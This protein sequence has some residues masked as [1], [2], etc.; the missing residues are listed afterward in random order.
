MTT[1][2]KTPRA[3]KRSAKHNAPDPITAAAHA[4]ARAA[5]A[6]A[7]ISRLNAD[8][9]L[10]ATSADRDLQSDTRRVRLRARDLQR[11]SPL[12]RRYL[13]LVKQNVVGSA[14]PRLQATNRGRDGKLD[15]ALNRYLEQQFREWAKRV[16]V[17]GRL[18]LL[19]YLWLCVSSLP[20]DGE[21]FT[22]RIV[23]Y[24]HN[25][26]GFALQALEPDLCDEQH[27]MVPVARTGRE[28][29]LGVEVDEWQRPVQYW[30][31]D[32]YPG[33]S[34]RPERIP[35]PASEVYHM[36]EP[37]R[38]VQTRGI[39]WL[40]AVMMNLRHVDGYV[41]AE[42]VATRAGSTKLGMLRHTDPNAS[43]DPPDGDTES[44]A[45]FEVDTS[46]GH[47][48]TL[49][50][51]L[52]F[53]A[54]DPQHPNSAMPAFLTMLQRWTASGLSVDF[55]GL[56]NNYEGASWSSLRSALLIERDTWRTF[57]ALLCAPGGL[58][59]WIYEGWLSTA[60]LTGAVQLPTPDWRMY[61]SHT[62][63]PRGW[64]WVDPH[65]EAKSADL[66]ER[67][68]MTTLRRIL[69]EKGEDLEDTIEE[70]AEIR[71]LLIA[72]GFDP[73]RPSTTSTG[74]PSG[75]AAESDT[76]GD[77]DG[78]GTEGKEDGDEGGD[79]E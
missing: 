1:T 14:V 13:Q 37:E 34:R 24:P 7:A 30:F 41:E 38:A 10:S 57:Q 35:V 72:H 28:I 53:V 36:Y 40:K 45:K 49:P 66:Q 55:H 17:D 61:S 48:D 56:A 5:H 64:T 12:V 8:W 50:P 44:F 67:R 47:I 18:S 31:D 73:D 33:E 59:P 63:Q 32:G 77:D 54:W 70:A 15:K 16:T 19:R 29:R 46:P 76:Q 39:S 52:D 21:Q 11:N 69:A 9:V 75:G 62:W 42:I 79:D 27:N 2:P 74:A 26:F 3:R 78:D 25:P 23:A 58:L 43:F 68:W 71:D 22:R 51:G 4:R 65:N 20:T 60:T 6:G